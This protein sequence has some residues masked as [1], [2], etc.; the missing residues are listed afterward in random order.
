MRDEELAPIRVRSGVRH[1]EYSRRVMP[2]RS[3][4]LIGEAVSGTTCACASG[5]PSLCHEAGNNPVERGPIVEA[6]VC[7]VDE[8]LDREGNHVPVQLYFEITMSRLESRRV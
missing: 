2:Q 6:G 3:V 4:E 5:I 7:Q 1:R 8:V